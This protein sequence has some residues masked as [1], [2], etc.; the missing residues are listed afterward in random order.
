MSRKTITIFFFLI[1]Y[2]STFA[3]KE[4]AIVDDLDSRFYFDFQFTETLLSENIYSKNNEKI[5]FK[6]YEFKAIPERKLTYESMFVFKSD[7]Y[8][9]KKFENENLSLA[10]GSMDFP[11]Q[12]FLNGIQIGHFGEFRNKYIAKTQYATNLQLSNSI[13]N[14]GDS[15]NT[16]V[17]QIYPR[18]GIKPALFK[19]FISSDL[20]VERWSF[21]KNFIRIDLVK[22]AS[23]FSVI[24]FLYFGLSFIQNR[25]KRDRKYLIFSFICI[26][27][28]LSYL[29]ISFSYNANYELLIYKI[30][31]F[32]SPILTYLLAI[33]TFKI[34]GIL[35][36][37]IFYK[38]L[39]IP[40]IFF[41]V[42]FLFQNDIENL[43]KKFALFAAVVNFPYIMLI[44]TVSLLSAIKTKK[45]NRI[46]FLI[47]LIVVVASII[48]DTVNFLSHV[49]P[50]SWFI[51]LGFF[52]F[53]ISIFFILSSEQTQIYHLAV[54]RQI[55]L[56]EIKKNLE[57]LVVERTKQ[58]ENQKNEIQN[59]NELLTE[60]NIE[61]SEK[62]T[63]L[64]QQK[65]EIVT[66]IHNLENLNLE[67]EIRNKIIENQELELRRK[68]SDSLAKSVELKNENIKA[69]LKATANQ[70]NP[71]FIFNTLN[72]IKFFILKNDIKT[73]DLFLEKFAKLMRKTLYNSIY[74][75]ITLKDEVETLTLYIELEQFRANNKFDFSIEIEDE[76]ILTYYKIPSLLIQ[77]FIENSIIHGIKTIEG[78]GIIDI[79]F[80]VEE[81]FL[82]CIIEDNGIGRKKSS[83]MKKEKKSEHK[84]VGINLISERLKLMSELYK[85]NYSFEY[86][87]YEI[88]KDQKTG[89]KVILNLPI[90][91]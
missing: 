40:A 37:K 26:L 80:R 47:G 16:I 19:Y 36:K 12:I 89:T 90:F 27:F 38:I 1:I 43:E 65:E 41:S 33:L 29:N 30:S 22:G 13:L 57:L 21:W 49:N 79:K 2:I 23:I 48:S 59:Q 39:F 64:Q 72:A 61:I 34:T 82:C 52:S 68:L 5:I 4:K 11:C 46:A 7:F 71:H 67:L 9:D 85:G 73:S 45:R 17:I 77:P 78:K 15:I 35:N 58:I 55:E 87:D 44:F 50:Y 84:S 54:D 18:K 6:D 74:E 62:N 8:V 28:S 25:D 42:I 20:K 56:Q 75:I 88:E 86:F 76:S 32:F 53:L 66:Q 60:K 91:E 24:L 69:Q 70:M 31:R 3:Q 10:V 14:Y 83:E 51:P 81:E 63:I